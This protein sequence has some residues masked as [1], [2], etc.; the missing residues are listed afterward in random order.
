MKTILLVDDEEA[1]RFIFK[2]GFEDDGYEVICAASGEEAL[3]LY[4]KSIYLHSI[5]ISL[6]ILDIQMPGM[7]G[8]EA[9]RQFKLRNQN[10]PVIICSAYQEFKRDLGTWASDKYVVKSGV[11]DELKTAVKNIIG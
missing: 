10:L 5:S 7:N 1:I 2:E 9:L 11:M 3:T 4:D 8:I 6:V